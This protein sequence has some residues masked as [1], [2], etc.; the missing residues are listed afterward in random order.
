MG[1]FF[2]AASATDLDVKWSQN[3]FQRI[4]EKVKGREEGREGKGRD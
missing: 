3:M 4:T 2:L 1:A